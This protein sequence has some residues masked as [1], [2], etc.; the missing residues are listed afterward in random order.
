MQGRKRTIKKR[1]KEGGNVR[2]G[3]FIWSGLENNGLGPSINCNGE[4]IRITGDIHAMQATKTN[5]MSKFYSI[6][7]P[8][9]A[10]ILG[11]TSNLHAQRDLDAMRRLNPR[12]QPAIEIDPDRVAAS[13]IQV[14][15]GKHVVV[16]TDIRDQADLAELPKVFDLAVDQWRAYFDID[17]EKL[18]G[19]Q[20]SAFVMQDRNR[21]DR[22]GLVP[23]EIPDF[24]AGYNLGHHMWVFHQPGNYYT[25]HLLLHEGTHS[26]M[27]WFLGG[28]GP[29]WFSEGM[30]EMLAVHRWSDGKLQL[31]YRLRDKSEAEYWGRVKLIRQDVEGG[32]KMSLEQIFLT[33]NNAFRNVR[34]YAWAWAACKFFSQ[35]PLSRAQFQNLHGSAHDSTAEFSRK[36]YR[37][38][39][40]DWKVLQKD[41]DLFVSEMDYGI[42][43]AQLTVLDA[44]PGNGREFS[45]DATR[46][47]QKTGIEVKKGETYLITSA[48]QYQIVDDGAPWPCEPGGVTIEYYRGHPLGM[49]MAGTLSEESGVEGLTKQQPIGLKGTFIAD[50]DGVLCLRVNE[51]PSRL[52]DNS[53]SLQVKVEQD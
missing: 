45:I 30:A 41:W 42:Q 7:L 23:A 13:G 28:S 22:A 6:L 29:P 11:W 51:S 44:V 3:L 8:L 10:V 26:F 37:T 32:E 25:R 15:E 9:C 33:P 24:P 49:L 31:N 47:W 21:F 27:Q 52:D 53:G 1:G 14:I 17:A 50:R 20:V 5:R 35:H 48:G 39:S 38:I 43:V 12:M 34:S 4:R 16:Y 46:G 19:W 18:E 36:F 40:N 2:I